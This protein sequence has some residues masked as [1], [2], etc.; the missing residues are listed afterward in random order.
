ML[1]GMACA[2]PWQTVST[3]R[4]ELMSSLGMQQHLNKFLMAGM[5]LAAAPV[6]LG[7]GTHGAFFWLL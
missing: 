1:L 3:K 4:K 6:Y 2:V 7:Q 5:Q